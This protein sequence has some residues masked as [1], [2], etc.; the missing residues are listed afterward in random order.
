[1]FLAVAGRRCLAIVAAVALFLTPHTLGAQE[2]DAQASSEADT[3]F[4]DA[5]QLLADKKYADAC[6]K[7]ARSQALDP[8]PGTVGLLAYCHELQGRTAT[9]W[10]EYLRTADLA[11]KLKQTEREQLA[12]ER[13]A[14]LQGKLSTIRISV[15][16]R[17]V[18]LVIERGDNVVPEAQWGNPIPVDPGK[19]D[20]RASAPGYLAW[21]A[22]VELTGQGAAV[23]VNVPRLQPNPASASASSQAPVPPDGPASA[24]ERQ[25]G[26]HGNVPALVAAGVGVVGLGLGSFFGLRAMSRNDDSKSHC[27]SS[28][29]CDPEGGQLRDDAKSA[30]TVSTV[31]F[32]LG[33]VGAA[34][35][36]VLW[37]RAK[38]A[39]P[40]S[41]P[42]TGLRFVPSVDK[43]GAGVGLR[44]WF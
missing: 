6:E 12:R 39:A 28:N 42:A 32:G 40:A 26:T 37:I 27:N 20:V 14:A 44:G 10:D 43:T 38:E 16:A 24:P 5:R 33:L 4:R 7:L 23:T 36:V 3:L 30:A 19:I 9:A 22:T 15:S 13:A 8:A 35:G 17:V 25:T 21:T 34:T 18:G 11:S 41:V 2:A 31:A 29:E 1:M